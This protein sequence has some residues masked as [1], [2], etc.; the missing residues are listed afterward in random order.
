[1]TN[2]KLANF[3]LAYRTTPHCT[4][5]EAPAKLLFGRDLPTRLTLLR[6]DLNGQ[7]YWKTKQDI[8]QNRRLRSLMEEDP[9]SVR[10]YR[11]QSKW[12]PGTV[13]RRTGSLSYQV[14]VGEATWNGQ[15]DQL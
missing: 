9:V 5:G 8:F 12:V 1:S 15:I 13:M 11:R 14:K 4:T 10:Y 3:L 7:M 2:K 6:P